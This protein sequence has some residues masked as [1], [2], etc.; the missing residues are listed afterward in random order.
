MKKLCPKEEKCY[1]ILMKDVLRPYVPEYKGQ[2]TCEDSDG[3]LLNVTN[4]NINHRCHLIISFMHFTFFKVV[5]MLKGCVSVAFFCLRLNL[6]ENQATILTD[7]CISNVYSGKTKKNFLDSE[8][9]WKREQT[10]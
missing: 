5:L 7:G 8:A 2:V 1:K 9:L 6:I 10:I 4:D 3:I